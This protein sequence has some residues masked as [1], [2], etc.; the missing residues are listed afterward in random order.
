[1]TNEKFLLGVLPVFAVITMV[2][3]RENSAESAEDLSE[4]TSINSEMMEEA[5]VMEEKT[6]DSMET[7]VDSLTTAVDSVAT[8]TVE[9]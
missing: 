4:E 1:M 7:T 3:C 2:S 9:Q 6:V 8:E 5:P